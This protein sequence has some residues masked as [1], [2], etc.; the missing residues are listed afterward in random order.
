MISK[1]TLNLYLYTRYAPPPAIANPIKI[2]QTAAHADLTSLALLPKN[3]SCPDQFLLW[4]KIM[5][6]SE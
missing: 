5:H 3:E 2:A 6:I 1:L 4:M